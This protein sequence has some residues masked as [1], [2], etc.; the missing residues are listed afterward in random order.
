MEKIETKHLI[1]RKAV[2]EDLDAIYHNIWQD[3]SIAEFMYWKPTKSYEEAVDR[4]NRT[5]A[6]QKKNMAYFVCLKDTDEA[7][8]FAGIRESEP[9]IFEESG[10][11]VATKYQNRGY[12]KEILKA[13]M[14]KAFSDLGADR[15]IYACM[16]HN[17][18]SRRVCKYF[19]F[20]YEYSREEVR[21][22]DS[23]KFVN[24]FYSLDRE[25]WEKV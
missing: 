21:E 24:D 4:L 8:G 22:W 23:K 6:Y 15:F 7:I 11:C 3:D 16:S 10:I 14:N 5:I 19:G 25:M 18:K 1:L 17:E 12:G 20:Q 2:P 13:L 9:G